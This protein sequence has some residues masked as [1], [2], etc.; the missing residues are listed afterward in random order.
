MEFLL[1]FF[2][3]SGRECRRGNMVHFKSDISVYEG[4]TQL[5][6][7]Q[8]IQYRSPNPEYLFPLDSGDFRPPPA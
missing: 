7:S 3:G 5:R 1:P 6:A 4:G 8:A 2:F